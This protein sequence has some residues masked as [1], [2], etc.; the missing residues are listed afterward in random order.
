M[1]EKEK[2]EKKRKIKENEKKQTQLRIEKQGYDP[3]D[4]VKLEKLIE[5]MLE[6]FNK[7]ISGLGEDCW[8]QEVAGKLKYSDGPPRVTPFVCP[9]DRRVLEG[10]LQESQPSWGCY[11]KGC[12]Y[13][14][15]TRNKNKELIKEILEDFLKHVK[16]GAYKSTFHNP[17]L[18][19]ILTKEQIAKL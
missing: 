5:Q 8:T 12:M 14:R 11:H 15:I 4:E 1:D 2:L 17:N 19:Q 16:S 10:G 3:R 7:G 6:N 18:P 9:W 13:H